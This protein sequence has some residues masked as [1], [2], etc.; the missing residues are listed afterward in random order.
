[1]KTKPGRI[2]VLI[3]SFWAIA[4]LSLNAQYVKPEDRQFNVPTPVQQQPQPQQQPQASTENAEPEEKW[5]KKLRPGGSFTAG[6]GTN[7]YLLVAPT[8]SY[9]ATDRFFPGVGLTYIYAS[10]TYN[11]T[12]GQYTYTSSSLGADIFARYIILENYFAMAQ[13]QVI[14]TNLKYPD[15]SKGSYNFSYPLLGGGYRLPLGSK[16]YIMLTALYNLNYTA[17]NKYSPYNSPIIYSVNFG[18]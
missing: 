9:K 4:Q 5:Y 14:Q 3:I 8:V 15:G 7:T 17:N 6:F 10:N 2:I 13:Y 1:M 18:F 11:T 12:G 16:G